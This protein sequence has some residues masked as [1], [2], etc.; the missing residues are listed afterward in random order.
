M[1]AKTDETDPLI[2]YHIP[3]LASLVVFLLFFSLE[4]FDKYDHYMLRV[5]SH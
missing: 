1:V 5:G 3:Q 4:Y 2:L